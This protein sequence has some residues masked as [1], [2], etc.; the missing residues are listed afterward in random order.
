MGFEKAQAENALK[1]CNG[2]VDAAL[3]KLLGG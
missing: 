3:N 1:E 2:D